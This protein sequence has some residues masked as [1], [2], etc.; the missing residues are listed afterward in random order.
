MIKHLLTIAFCLLFAIGIANA[1]DN[2]D[3]KPVIDEGC[4]AAKPV[5]GLNGVCFA[6]NSLK[7]RNSYQRYLEQCPQ[8]RNKYKA[9]RENYKSDIPQEAKA[10][11]K[12]RQ[13]Q[14]QNGTSDASSSD[15]GNQTSENVSSSSSNDNASS[16]GKGKSDDNKIKIGSR[17]SSGEKKVNNCPLDMPAMDMSGTCHKCSDMVIRRNP[18][19]YANVCAGGKPVDFTKPP[20]AGKRK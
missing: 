6:C 5:K 1:A 20:A 11:Q 17:K 18:G 9:T 12:Q 2:A 3:N 4:T 10:M 16:S 7:I 15:G 19:R 14:S 13:N 8:Y